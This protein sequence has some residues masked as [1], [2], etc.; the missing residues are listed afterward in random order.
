LG[1]P[2]ID[3]DAEQFRKLCGLQCTLS[4]IS[5]YFECS[6]DTVERWCKRTF[7]MSFESLFDKYSG[8]ARIS[9]R[10]KQ[11]AVAMGGDRTMLIWLGKQYLNQKDKE[12]MQP[13]KKVEVTITKKYSASEGK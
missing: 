7:K 11:Y 1:R 13:D 9:L 8:P 5:S 10:R 12:E 2:K 4:E 6:E 3:I